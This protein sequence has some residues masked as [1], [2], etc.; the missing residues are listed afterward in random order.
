MKLRCERDVFRDALVTAGRAA[1]S[2][3]GMPQTLSG[4]HLSLAGDRLR[5]T[6]TDRELTIR[7]ETQ[8]AGLEDGDCVVPAGLTGDIV[9]SLEPGAVVVESDDEGARISAGRSQFS[10]RTYPVDEF[11]LVNPPAGEGFTLGASDLAEALRQVVRAAARDDLRPTL[12]GVLIA[13]E[14]RGIRLL[15]T[16]SYRLAQRDL[17]GASLPEG[18]R[19]L[20]PARAL[21]ELQRLLAAG[22]GVASLVSSPEGEAG[23]GRRVTVRLGDLD[24]TFEVGAVVLTT[25]L[26]GAE[27]PN[28]AQLFPPSYPNRL[29]VGKEPLLDA[30]R[31][32]K[33]LVHDEKS[34]VRMT[35]RPEGIQL[36]A[37]DHEKGQA[38][39]ELDAKYEGVELTIAFNPAY[40]IEGVDALRGDE[41]LMEIL[42]AA[43]PATVRG[44]E[45]DPYRYL[46]MP[47]RVA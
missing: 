47:I 35:V 43:R 9:R 36:T 10:V 21:S 18:S 30:L 40:L 6:A 13:G 23:E 22:G 41:V 42:D 28:T 44:S 14:E 12:N 46:I 7:V 32:V 34:P 5:L 15:A 26:I 2:G 37:S 33:L 31:R 19:V 27:F 1:T 24:A 8:V 45:D 29:V 38:S 25:R 39:E 20:V 11:P 17:E 4:I 3:T 16:D